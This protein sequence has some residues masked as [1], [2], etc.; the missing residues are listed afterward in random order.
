MIKEITE[1]FKDKHKKLLILDAVGAFVTARTLFIIAKY[2]SHQFGIAQQSVFQ[3]SAVAVVFC[4]F[5]S[6]SALFVKRNLAPFIN[7]I[8][9]A[10]ISYVLY[11]IILLL[12]NSTQVTS[13]AYVYFAIEAFIVLTLAYI[14]LSVVAKKN[15]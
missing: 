13:I 15:Q 4:I 14:E 2:F 6:V 10:N 7:I 1:Y 8:A 9:Y 5:S 12:S 3:L 11:T